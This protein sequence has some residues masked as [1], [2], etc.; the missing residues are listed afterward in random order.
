MFDSLKRDIVLNQRKIIQQKNIDLK[1]KDI[2][3]KKKN[4]QLKNKNKE[5][6]EILNSTSW[7]STKPLRK[8]KSVFK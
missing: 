4:K 2:E 6:N 7:K 8:F 3:F 1:K 5:L